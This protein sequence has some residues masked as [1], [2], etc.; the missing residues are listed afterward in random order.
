[1]TKED[2][3][4]LGINVEDLTYPFGDMNIIVQCFSKSL[5]K[6]EKEDSKISPIL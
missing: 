5:K 6:I 2:L 4:N 1:M 3:K